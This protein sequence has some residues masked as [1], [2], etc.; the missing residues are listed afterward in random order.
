MKHIVLAGALTLLATPALAGLEICNNAA[1]RLSLAIGY[2]SDGGWVSEGW[3]NIDPGACKTTI[4]G[5]LKNR[6]YYYRANMSGDPF[7]TG[8]YSFCTT[9][10]AFTIKGDE[11]CV[12]R[13]YD[14]MGFRKLDTGETATHFTLTLNDNRKSQKDAAAKTVTPPPVSSTG[15]GT[16]GEPYSDNVILQGC[17]SDGGRQCNFHARG[18]S[19]FVYDDGRTPQFVF[20]TMEALD[21][22][23]PLSV[24]GDLEAVYDRTADVVLQDVSVRPWS[25]YDGLLNQLQGHWYSEDDPNSQ[26]TILGAERENTYDGSF[27]G[28]EY[29]WVSERCDQFE[30]GGPYLYAREE[31]TGES[32]CYQIAYVDQLQLELMY[33]PRGNILRYRKLD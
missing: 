2:S 28:V 8:D 10:E 12:D 23:T 1:E 5:D 29:L 22:G 15:P 9:K 13:G 17:V 30:G 31:E 20:T 21:P 32:Y 18:T 3:W 19:F 14:A 25:E 4:S 11:N 7:A 33:L 24:E 27:M 26:F 16:Y 6:Y